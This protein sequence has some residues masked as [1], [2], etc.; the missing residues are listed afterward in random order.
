[1]ARIAAAQAELQDAWSRLSGELVDEYA[2]AVMAADRSAA[3]ARIAVFER[4]SRRLATLAAV[5]AE[6]LQRAVEMTP[7]DADALLDAL[8]AER[9]ADSS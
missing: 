9:E 6:W 7:E 8:I 3:E 1:M 2:N 4:R 5:E